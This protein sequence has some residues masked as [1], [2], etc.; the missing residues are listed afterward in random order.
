MSLIPKSHALQGKHVLLLTP[1]EEDYP[2][3]KKVLNDRVTMRALMPFFRIEEWT[4][5]Q[6][7]ERYE[8]FQREQEAG[9]GLTYAIIN[10]AT[11]EI[12]GNCGFKKI[13]F[14]LR[15]AEYGIILHQSK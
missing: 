8:R 10:Q 14:E 2:A 7:R 5:T 4:N 6:V 3:L 11:L 9:T 13:D 12:V 1:V 15:Q